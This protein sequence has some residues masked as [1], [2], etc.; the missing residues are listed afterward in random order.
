MDAVWLIGLTFAGTTA[1]WFA[2]SWLLQRERAGCGEG[3]PPW[4]D[5]CGR[6]GGEMPEPADADDRGDEDE[7]PPSVPFSMN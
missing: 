1:F 3:V 5:Y 4:V 2:V 6:C 7:A